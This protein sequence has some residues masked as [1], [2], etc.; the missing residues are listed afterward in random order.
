M[1][2]SLYLVEFLLVLTEGARIAQA[3]NSPCSQ[4]GRWLPGGKPD[5]REVKWTGHMEKAM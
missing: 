1:F 5:A 2:L 4:T 3:S